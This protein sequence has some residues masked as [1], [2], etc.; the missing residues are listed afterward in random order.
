MR[1]GLVVRWIATALL[2]CSPGPGARGGEPAA[3][4]DDALLDD[5]ERRSFAWFW[6]TADPA[7]GLIPDRHPTPSFSSIAAVGF[8]LTAIPVG[9]ERG[10]VD[11]AAARRRVL[12]TLRFFRD[13][14]QSA[15]AQGATGYRGFYYHFLDMERGARFKDVELSTI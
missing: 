12:A 2:A 10:W 14:P 15:A 7:T 11:R 5:I 4:A 3:A 1:P 6:R 8:G 9:V 13:A